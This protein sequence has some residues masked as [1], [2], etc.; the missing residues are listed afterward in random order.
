MFMGGS[1]TVYFA[2]KS[3]M[4]GLGTRLP[5]KSKMLFFPKYAQQSSELDLSIGNDPLG[6]GS[7]ITKSLPIVTS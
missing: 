7:H 6:T 3:G 5:S 1:Y 2:T 4:T